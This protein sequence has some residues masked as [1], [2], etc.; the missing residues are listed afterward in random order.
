MVMVAVA[1]A[2]SYN[3][4]SVKLSFELMLNYCMMTH[5]QHYLFMALT[6]AFHAL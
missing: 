4:H 2:A 1:V 6:L 5:L 3:E